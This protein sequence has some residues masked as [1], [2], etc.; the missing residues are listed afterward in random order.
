VCASPVSN[1]GD[2]TAL[3]SDQPLDWDV[4]LNL[5]QLH[6]VEGLLAKRLKE[7]AF[8]GV[9]GP[10]REKLQARMRARNLFTLSMTAE[11]FRIVDDFS[12]SQIQTALVK[13]PVISFLAYG[14]PAVR[15]YVDLDL[16]LRDRDIQRA[17]DRMR[18]LGFQFL[19][20]ES[21]ISAGKIP[22]EY[23]FRREGTQHILELHTEH[24]FRYYPRTMR[25]EDLLS[26]S[27]AVTF[28][29]RDIPA[30]SLEDEFVLD[31]VHGAK[32]FWERLMWVAD[33]A[34][35]VERHPEID[36]NKAKTAAAQV[37]AT[38]M[39]HV[40]L[41]LAS[42]VLGTKLPSALASESLADRTS[43]S[44]C[45]QIRAWLPH[46]GE[47]PPSLPG[48]AA[49]RLRIADGILEGAGYLGR[50][51]LSPTQDDWDEGAEEQRSWLWDAVRRPF[52]LFRKYGSNE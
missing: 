50:L 38:R 41:R 37:G 47:A 16:I 26:R 52:R 51:S 32:H 46:A 11:L 15:S 35:L 22:G 14:D 18:Q 5:S 8:A 27:R 25:I 34:A 10:A 7:I 23:L 9:P 2:I 29:G 42:A 1:P 49:F 44:L 28:D 43:E 45:R 21:A 19:L 13:G 33:V 31:C 48:R 12:Q 40:G 6:G 3:V 17:T 24:T 39:L 20:P 36:W 4:L 30:L